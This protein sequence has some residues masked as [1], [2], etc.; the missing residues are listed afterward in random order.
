MRLSAGYSAALL[1]TGKLKENGQALV[2]AYLYKPCNLVI[3]I[4]RGFPRPLVTVA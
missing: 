2:E 1:A 4:V 3:P